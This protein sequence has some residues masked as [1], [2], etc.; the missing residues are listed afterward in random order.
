[1]RSRRELLAAVLVAPIAAALPVSN[2]ITDAQL[3]QLCAEVGEA[4]WVS[5]REG[6][7]EW[8]KA[9]P[10]PGLLVIGDWNDTLL[11]IGD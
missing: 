1:M 2:V 9:H 7:L 11:V 8:A 5:I 3:D 6:L 4:R 10:P